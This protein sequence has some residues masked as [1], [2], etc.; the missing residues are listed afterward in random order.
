[1]DDLS[2]HVLDIAQN[3]VLARATRIAIRVEENPED[4]RLVL[5]IVDDGEGMDEATA[6]AALDPFMTSRSG[7]KWGLGLP[8]LRE[9]AR[10]TGG[11]LELVSVPGRGTTVRVWFGYSH[12]DRQPLGDMGETVL[13][14]IAGNPDLT[15]RYEH[16]RAGEEFVLDTG[17]LRK[18]L[19][20][21]PLAD[22]GILGALRRALRRA[23]EPD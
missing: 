11:D 23:L 6:R 10:A 20:G 21:T 15:I 9:Q 2:L 18:E 5:E 12:V 19:G 3:S 4:D 16:V 14:L 7:K 22:P 17:E 8:H 1:M 13:T